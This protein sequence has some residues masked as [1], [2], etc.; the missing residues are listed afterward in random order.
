[1]APVATPLTLNRL[2][3]GECGIIL[4]V[5][6]GEELDQRLIAL[7]LRVGKS[8]HLLRRARFGGP[9]HV[10][11]GTTELML[12]IREARCIHLAHGRSATP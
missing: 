7:G 2:D 1:M 5:D 10:R 9:L 8:V 3:P 6:A 12:R 4:A 11:V